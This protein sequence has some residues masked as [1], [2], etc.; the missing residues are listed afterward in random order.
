MIECIGITTLNQI[1]NLKSLI[2]SIDYPVKTVSILC[3][4]YSVDY[5]LKV[6]DCCENKYVEEFIISHCPY[7]MGCSTSWNYHIKM[8]PELNGWIICADDIQFSPGDLENLHI[9]SQNTDIIFANIPPKFSLFYISKKCVSKVGFFDEN[10]HPAC[11]EDDDYQRRLIE[12]DIPILTF[13][14]NGVHIGSGTGKSMSLD[15]RKKLHQ[16]IKIN[17]EYYQKKIENKD[18][19]SGTFDFN[20]RAKNLLRIGD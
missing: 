10:I 1:D 20:Q 14:F 15:K 7:N 18:F 17:K 8:N 19:T 5:Y 2:Q 6:R 4:S 3:N 9:K 11:Y 12:N 13:N 16:A